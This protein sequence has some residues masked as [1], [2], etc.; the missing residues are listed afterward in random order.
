MPPPNRPRNEAEHG[1]LEDAV[2]GHVIAGGQVRFADDRLSGEIDDIPSSE[3]YRP[4]PQEFAYLR[5][6]S[7]ERLKVRIDGATAVRAADIG[8][9][10]RLGTRGQCRFTVL[11]Q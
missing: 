3:S 1:Y 2:T 5:L 9:H 7:G 8:E 4:G 6:S 11:P 10:V